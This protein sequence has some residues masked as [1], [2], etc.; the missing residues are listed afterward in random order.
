MDKKAK[1]RLEVLKQKRAALEK[2]LA[3]AKK[4][5]DDPQEIVRFEKEL[6]AIKLEMEQLQ[7]S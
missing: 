4:Q 7:K 1:K 5:T 3:G 6:A 2:Q